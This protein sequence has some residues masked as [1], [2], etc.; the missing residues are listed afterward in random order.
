MFC[1]KLTVMAGRSESH[2]FPSSALHLSFLRSKGILS[3][4]R[5]SGGWGGLAV[6]G[7]PWTMTTAKERSGW[8]INCWW[9]IDSR[10]MPSL[11]NIFENQQCNVEVYLRGW[12][13]HPYRSSVSMLL[14]VASEGNTPIAWEL[15]RNAESECF[16]QDPK[17]IHINIG[18]RVTV[19]SHIFHL[20]NSS[21]Y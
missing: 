5:A 1:P 9:I 6:S 18:L 2:L 20:L 12:D 15:V 8:K 10:D 21:S 16:E 17:V 3:A 13:Y 11:K 19:L 7:V 4:N 14:R